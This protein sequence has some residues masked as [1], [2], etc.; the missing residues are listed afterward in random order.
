MIFLS[1]QVTL[2]S[3]ERHE[4]TKLFHDF[5]D[6]FSVNVARYR[7]DPHDSDS[8]K[9]GAYL[10]VN[11]LGILLNSHDSDSRKGWENDIEVKKHY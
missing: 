11:L 3:P 1:F 6:M 7:V 10:V 8:M 4:L 2:V 9:G 5:S